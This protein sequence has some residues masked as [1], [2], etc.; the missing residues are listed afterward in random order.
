M[1]NSHPEV[2]I[3]NE[4]DKFY[5]HLKG[6]FNIQDL[7]EYLSKTLCVSESNLLGQKQGTTTGPFALLEAA[8]AQRSLES[9]K[10]RWGIKDPHLTYSLDEF[11]RHYPRAKFIFIVRDP[12]AV[13]NSYITRKFNVANCYYGA[14]LWKHEASLQRKFREK[15]MDD[16][17]LI[18]Y[19]DLLRDKTGNLTKICDFVGI[20]YDPSME[21]YFKSSAKTRLHAGTINI[22]K[23]VDPRISEKWRTTL[24][25]KQ[26]RL[27]ESITSEEAIRHQ[28]EIPANSVTL[29]FI[30]RG[31]YALHQWIVTT[32]IWQ[33]HTHWQGLR[34]RLSFERKK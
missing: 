7:T 30:H 6:E 1:L 3:C 17:L 33:R 14:K 18:H 11:K 34:R 8:F 2:D 20:S 12:R 5:P 4:L 22:T 26:L 24:S 32:Y 28:Y 27:I 19:E 23:D 15:H 9:G 25:Q 16:S 10:R 29:T 31:Y 21:S 13:V